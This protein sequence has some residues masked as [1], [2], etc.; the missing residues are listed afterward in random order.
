[1]SGMA[2]KMGLVENKAGR[3]GD[4]RVLSHRECWEKASD[5]VTFEWRFV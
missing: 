5:E 2:R 1:M 4:F 3:G